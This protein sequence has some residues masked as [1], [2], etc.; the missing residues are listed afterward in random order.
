MTR[1]GH[2]KRVRCARLRHRAHR[3]R[4][5][6]PPSDLSIACG[7]SRRDAADGVPYPPLESGAA[8]VER[9]VETLRGGI[10]E[11]H[12]LGHELLYGLVAA[13]QPRVRET[14]LQTTHQPIRIVAEVDRTD[15]LVRRGD[16]DR[17]ERAF[18][19]RKANDVATAASPELRWRHA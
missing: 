15:A 5:A 13:D 10:D 8:N 16:Q 2:R 3:L 9:E 17:S 7:Q 11:A 6:N 14:I 19:D 1:N 12:H 4:R 18:A